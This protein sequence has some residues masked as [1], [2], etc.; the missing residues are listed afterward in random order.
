MDNGCWIEVR[1]RPVLYRLNRLSGDVGLSALL[2]MNRH[3]FKKDVL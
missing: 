3:A 2:N 1:D